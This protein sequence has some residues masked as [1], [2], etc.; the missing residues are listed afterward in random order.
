M[1]ISYQEGRAIQGFGTPII[2]LGI[3]RKLPPLVGVRRGEVGSQLISGGSTAISA[4]Y[5]QIS[6]IY[7]HIYPQYEFK[8]IFPG[9]SFS[10]TLL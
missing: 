5:I 1:G 2:I 6:Q 3:F 4:E 7:G 10:R 9:P 8:V